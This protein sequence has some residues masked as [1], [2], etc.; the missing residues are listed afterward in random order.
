M[1]AIPE[2]V[3]PAPMIV[4]AAAHQEYWFEEGCFIT[5]LLNSPDDPAL[6]VARA[7]VTPGVTTRLHRLEGIAERYVILAGTGRVE[8]V[9]A[10]RQLTPGN[11]TV[12][13]LEPGD[14]VVVPPGVSQR[15]TNI[16]ETDLVFLAL[17]TPRFTRAAY[18]DNEK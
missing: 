18:Q 4:R 3:H 10:D 8:L 5:E 9:G 16:G 1:S 13:D 12:S 2:P 11:H 15:I 7:R 6:S 17:C 14:V